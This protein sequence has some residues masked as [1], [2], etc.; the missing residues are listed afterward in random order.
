MY[1][2]V[3]THP[4]KNQ[5]IAEEMATGDNEGY[6]GNSDTILKSKLYKRVNAI[7]FATLAGNW[8]KE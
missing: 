8:D 1:L 4:Q 5:G 7:V 3:K 6:V 2:E